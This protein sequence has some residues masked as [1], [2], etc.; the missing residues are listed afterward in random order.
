MRARNVEE[1]LER[2]KITIKA[3][4]LWSSNWASTSKLDVVVG[5]ISKPNLGLTQSTW[6]RL[7]DEVDVVIH[8]GAQVNWIL[9][10]SS[11]RAANVLRTLDCVQL[12]ASGKPKRLAVISST[13][14]L[15]CEHYIRMPKTPVLE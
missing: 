15:D 10:Y 11:L 2:L 4:G 3:Y 14:T 6:E 13:S 1:G 5:D 7:I 12:C 8:N 9:P